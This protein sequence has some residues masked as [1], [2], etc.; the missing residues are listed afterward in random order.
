MKVIKVTVFQMTVVRSSLMTKFSLQAAWI[1]SLVIQMDDQ[2]FVEI[3]HNEID[4]L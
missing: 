1:Q 4:F 2:Q 3:N